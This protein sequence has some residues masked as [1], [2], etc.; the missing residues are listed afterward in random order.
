MEN[1]HL[2]NPHLDGRPFFWQ[3]GPVGVFLSYGFNATSAEL[4]HQFMGN[5]E[6][7]TSLKEK[8]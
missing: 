6:L 5:V 1:P 4:S 8:F 7:I 2:L 3:A